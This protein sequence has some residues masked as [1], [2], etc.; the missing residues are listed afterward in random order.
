MRKECVW[1]DPHHPMD[2]LGPITPKEREGEVRTGMCRKS[3][4]EALA[5]LKDLGEIEREKLAPR[6]GGEPSPFI[7]DAPLPDDGIPRQYVLPARVVEAV[8]WLLVGG[9]VATVL[10]LIL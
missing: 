9:T 7:V 8:A 6:W 3:R 4:E 2:G 1:C 5:E 10:W